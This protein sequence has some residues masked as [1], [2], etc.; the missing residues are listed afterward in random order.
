MYICRHQTSNRQSHNEDCPLKTKTGDIITDRNKQICRWVK[1]YLEIYSRKN[2]V[3]DEALTAIKDLPVVEEL[4]YEPTLEELIK[5]IDTPKSN[6]VAGKDG[7]PPEIIKFGK[8][9]ILKHLH[10]LLCLC[11]KEDKVPQDM[12]NAKIVTL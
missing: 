7:I 10:N 8:L 11:W 9:V 1:H 5:A 2:I 6:Q 3:I 12:R 4:D